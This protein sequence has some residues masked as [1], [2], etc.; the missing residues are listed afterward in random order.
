MKLNKILHN[1]KAFTLVELLV[2][3]S[4]FIVVIIIAAETFNIVVT[5]SGKLSKSEESNI[6]GVIGLE[7]MRHDLE[8]MGFGLLWGFLPGTTYSYSE[9]DTTNWADDTT[10]YAKL[11]D[12][13]ATLPNRP[14]PR[15]LV[16]FNA[17]SNFSSDFIGVKGTTVGRSKAAQ[18]WTYIPFNNFSTTSGRESRPVAWPSNNLSSGDKVIAVRSNFNDPEDDHLLLDASGSF[19]FNFNT[20]GLIHSAYLPTES[21]QTHMVYGLDRSSNSPRMPFN[22]TDFFVKRPDSTITGDTAMP[23]FCA[24]GTGT[25]YKATVNQSDGKYTYI[26]L[27]D[28]VANMQVVLGWSLNS[29]TDKLQDAVHAYSSLPDSS[30]YSVSVVPA[31]AAIAL[32]ATTAADIQDWLQDPKGVREHLKILKVYLLVQEGKR[33]PK[34]T[35]PA[36]SIVVGDQLNGELILTRQYPLTDDQRKYRWKLYK[37]IVRPKNLVSNQR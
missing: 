17:F 33:D 3:M 9:T 25:L 23:S 24:P 18:F 1:N 5:Q 20:T 21:L 13:V 34:Y 8:Q 30:D 28:C 27:L 11:N 36:S 6:E 16:G 29:G 22:R 2:T 37:L 7:V 15:A 14:V 32:P 4:V 31:S 19:G 10:N 12:N 35:Y 26:P